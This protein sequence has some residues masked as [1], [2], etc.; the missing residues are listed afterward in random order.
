MN[1]PKG[2]ATNAMRL[3]TSSTRPMRPVGLHG[4][5]LSDNLALDVRPFVFPSHVLSAILRHSFSKPSV[6]IG[7]GQIVFAVIPGA[8]EIFRQAHTQVHHG[9]FRG[10]VV[11]SAPTG[12]SALEL[13]I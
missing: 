4:P 7:P 8:G 1:P 10:G 2:L 9:G 13:A 3:A 12:S 11:G 6:R 5:D